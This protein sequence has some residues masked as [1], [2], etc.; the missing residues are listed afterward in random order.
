MPV[1][2]RNLVA[3]QRAMDL[4]V[5]I[6]DLNRPLRSLTHPELASQLMR[7]AVSVPSNIA[8]GRGRS[9]SRE[10]AHFLDFSTGSLR[11]VE[12]LVELI[13]RLHLAKRYDER[14]SQAS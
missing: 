10:F 8:E 5:A 4:T 12:T 1:G 9:S 14:A 13:A 3:W 7:A 11:E 2:H 6:Y